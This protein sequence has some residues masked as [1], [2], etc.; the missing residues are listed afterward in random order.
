MWE[1][2]SHRIEALNLLLDMAGELEEGLIS[3]KKLVSADEYE[4]AMDSI[5]ELFQ[6]LVDSIS[7]YPQTPPSHP[8]TNA[9][10]LKMMNFRLGELKLVL[11]DTNSVRQKL[12]KLSEEGLQDEGE[13]LNQA[14]SAV[15]D[16][17]VNLKGL[18]FDVSFLR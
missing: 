14:V 2:C 15:E 9:L 18:C 16:Y 5:D 6:T 4:R 13:V 3:V 1:D 17:L 11:N 7:R 8:N 10:D 12:K